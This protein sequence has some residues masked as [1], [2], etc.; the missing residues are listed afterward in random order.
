MFIFRF[1]RDVIKFGLVGGWKQ[2]DSY[3]KWLLII[4]GLIIAYKPL[5]NVFGV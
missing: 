5:V 3:T 1:V 4:F 2:Q